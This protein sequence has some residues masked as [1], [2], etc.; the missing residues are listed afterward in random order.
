MKFPVHIPRS[1]RASRRISRFDVR[2]QGM[3]G[4]GGL[5]G[6]VVGEQAVFGVARPSS[7]SAVGRTRAGVPQA[8]PDPPIDLLAC[9]WPN[10]ASAVGAA[11][12]VGTVNTASYQ[13]LRIIGPMRAVF[14]RGD[15]GGVR[16][17]DHGTGRCGPHGPYELGSFSAS[18]A[19]WRR[20]F[21][22]C[23]VAAFMALVAALRRA[24]SAGSWAASIAASSSIIA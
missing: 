23:N 13:G 18:L 24:I 9:G 6:Q 3:P 14:A 19:P 10:G 7:W 5:E 22:A 15:R 16:R 12:A 8:V 1:P 2:V 17:S 11:L 21:S 4:G 20:V